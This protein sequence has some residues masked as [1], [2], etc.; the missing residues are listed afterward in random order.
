MSEPEHD[1]EEV[2]E[3]TVQDLDDNPVWI[4]S[5]ETLIDGVDDIKAIHVLTSAFRGVCD[6]GEPHFTEVSHFYNQAQARMLA[7]GL[8]NAADELDQLES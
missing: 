3:P 7:A 4:H 6:M 8:L 5:C 1:A 2:L